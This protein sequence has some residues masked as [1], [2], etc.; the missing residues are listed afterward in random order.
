MV[1]HSTT[2]KPNDCSLLDNHYCVSCRSSTLNLI[3][4]DIVIDDV[5]VVLLGLG[6]QASRASIPK[7]G[8]LT[9]VELALTSH[10]TRSY[11]LI[12]LSALRKK[13]IGQVRLDNINES[14]NTNFSLTLVGKTFVVV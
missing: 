10:K 1:I 2:A 7:G 9:H 5:R 14:Q 11:H 4:L 13:Q 6:C 3:L 8:N 12:V